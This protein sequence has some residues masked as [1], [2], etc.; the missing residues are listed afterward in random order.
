MI[1]SDRAQVLLQAA[2]DFFND[3]NYQQFL[4]RA[5]RIVTHQAIQND[6]SKTIIHACLSHF[7]L[8]SQEKRIDYMFL[9]LH[10]LGHEK[11]C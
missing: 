10:Y 2:L 9:H 4:A 1:L 3:E 11:T 7:M 8:V 6:L 5:Y